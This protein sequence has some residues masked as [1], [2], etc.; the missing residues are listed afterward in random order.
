MLEKVLVTDDGSNIVYDFYP[1][2]DSQT[3][4]LIHGNAGNRHYFD[5]QVAVYK[6]NFQIITFDTRAHGQ[7][8]NESKKLTFDQI[9]DDLKELLDTEFIKKAVLMGF[10]DGANVAMVFARKYPTKI[11]G[12]ILNAGNFRISGLFFWVRFVDA[13]LYLLTKVI[14]FVTTKVNRYLQVQSLLFQ[15]LPFDWVELK[16]IKVPTLIIIGKHDVVRKKHTKKIASLI[17]NSKL[18]ITK[19]GHLYGKKNPI[20]FANMVTQFI[21]QSRRKK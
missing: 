3:L 9:A 16:K 2:K 13:V 15:N 19:G 5:S 6:K 20:K 1:R 10:S 12:L 8:S 4:V 14:S 17:P 18:E 7:S 11:S 21:K